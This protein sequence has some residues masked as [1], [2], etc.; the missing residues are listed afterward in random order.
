MPSPTS[1]RG[2]GAPAVVRWHRVGR[3]LGERALTPWR[4][5]PSCVRCRA[6]RSLTPSPRRGRPRPS[7]RAVRDRRRAAHSKCEDTRGAPER[8]ERRPRPVSS[9]IAWRV[10]AGCAGRVPR[11]HAV[12]LRLEPRLA[13]RSE[14]S[15]AHASDRCTVCTLRLTRPLRNLRVRVLIA[16]ASSQSRSARPLAAMTTGWSLCRWSIAVPSLR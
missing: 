10:D 16:Q 9:M 14:A 1:R 2:A 8:Q 11:G 15:V 7:G 6:A 5:S 12:G 4:L 3:S 13:A